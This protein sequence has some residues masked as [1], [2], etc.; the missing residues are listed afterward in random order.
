M[1]RDFVEIDQKK[2][3]MMEILEDRGLSFLFPLLRVQ[4][5]LWKEMQTDPSATGLF[6][7]IKEHVGA[8]LH[9]TTG[10]LNVLTTRYATVG[11]LEHF[12]CSGHTSHAVHSS[13]LGVL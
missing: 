2:E 4:A 7:W 5:E 1:W 11:Q 6:K 8:D 9:Y 13:Y 12:V 10:F 3:R